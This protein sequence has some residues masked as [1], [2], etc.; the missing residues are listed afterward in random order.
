MNKRLFITL[1]YTVSQ[2][3]STEL[4]SALYATEK[5]IFFYFLYVVIQFVSIVLKK[6]LLIFALV[7]GQKLK[8]NISADCKINEEI[9]KIS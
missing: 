9:I 2:K 7:V 5:K 6:L 8:K 4:A 1:I 3:H